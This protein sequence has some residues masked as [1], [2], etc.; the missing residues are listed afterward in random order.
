M[1]P[2]VPGKGRE[3][4]S[5]CWALS[6]SPRD[7]TLFPVSCLSP[8]AQGSFCT[9]TA[10]SRHPA[11]PC[12]S[13]PRQHCGASPQPHLTVFPALPTLAHRTAPSH[14]LEAGQQFG[15]QPSDHFLH[16]ISDTCWSLR[17]GRT[18]ALCIQSPAIRRMRLGIS[19]SPGFSFLP[20]NRRTVER[21]LKLDD[22]KVLS[23]VPCIVSSW[24]WR[25]RH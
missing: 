25:S 20:C 15:A 18:E 22:C 16:T 11:P 3:P 7:P 6:S 13:P 17:P 4:Q 8:T 2:A 1:S 21:I 5:L 10:A 12:A 24:E 23:F 14:C 9:R 19:L